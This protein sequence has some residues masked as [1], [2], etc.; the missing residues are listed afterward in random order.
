MMYCVFLVQPKKDGS[1]LWSHDLSRD[2]QKV[3]NE[4]D[5]VSD[6]IGQCWMGYS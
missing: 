4:M 6:G 3:D 1:F 2:L 5:T